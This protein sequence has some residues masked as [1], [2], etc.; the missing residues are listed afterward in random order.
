MDRTYDVDFSEVIGQEHAKRGLE[1]AA[2]GGHNILMIGPP[3]SGKTMLA[4]R[5]P[6]IMPDMTLEEAIETTK[7]HSAAG[8]LHPG[9]ALVCTRPFRSPHHTVSDAGLIGGG[10]FP[11]PGE[12]SLAHSGVLFLD[13]FPE[14]KRSVLEALRQPL[15]DGCVTVSRASGSITFP[16][17][18]MLASSMNPCPCGTLP[19]QSHICEFPAL[20]NQ[21]FL[22]M[23]LNLN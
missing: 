2:A 23:N 21:S 17:R 6:T 4:R 16:A 9:Q 18:F 12:I 15:E 13:E 22:D 7:I 11:H 5:L 3:G 14:F 20:Q 1:V 10:N 19:Q 8:F